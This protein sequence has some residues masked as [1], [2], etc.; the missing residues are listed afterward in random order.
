MIGK[1]S[2]EE[3]ELYGPWAWIA[4]IIIAAVIF[5]IMFGLAGGFS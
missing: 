1:D 5:G 4:G 3:I 2:K